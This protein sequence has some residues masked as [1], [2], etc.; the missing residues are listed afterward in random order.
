MRIVVCAW[1]V[2]E[3][4]PSAVVVQHARIHEPQEVRVGWPDVTLLPRR[5]TRRRKA[6]SSRSAVPVTDTFFVEPSARW[7]GVAPS[8]EG[9]SRPNQ[10]TVFLTEMSP[11]SAV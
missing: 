3:V 7:R 11:S 5:P 2:R 9:H 4:Q 6:R 10:V 1:L 8:R